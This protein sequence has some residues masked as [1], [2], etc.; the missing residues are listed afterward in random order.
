MK[1]IIL[2]LTL[3]V[4]FGIGV[5]LPKPDPRIEKISLSIPTESPS[6]LIGNSI[7]HHN[8]PCD[9]DLEISTSFD[10]IYGSGGL[11]LEEI[12]FSLSRKNIDSLV[13][14]TGTYQFSQPDYYSISNQFYYQG[15]LSDNDNYSKKPLWGIE[16]EIVVDETSYKRSDLSNMIKIWIGDNDFRCTKNID[17]SNVEI[18]KLEEITRHS[19]NNFNLSKQQI[20]RLKRLGESFNVKLVLVQPYIF[21]SFSN[22]VKDS[23]RLFNLNLRESIPDNIEVR[24]LQDLENDISYY[25]EPWCMCGHL[26]YEGRKILNEALQ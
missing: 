6:L 16:K 25:D 1:K 19:Y 7:I 24:W 3:L 11:L 12:E 4:S 23:F 20:Q 26:N 14:V 10:A 13:I 9:D 17:F 5:I 22:E 18:K 15:R 2:V 21:P 8:S